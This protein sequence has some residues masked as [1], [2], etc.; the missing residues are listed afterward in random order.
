MDE[1]VLMDTDIDEGSVILR[2]T[3]FDM[4]L[5]NDFTTD[6]KHKLY[7]TKDYNE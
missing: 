7:C 5:P 2:F 6:D 3:G 1:S 4:A